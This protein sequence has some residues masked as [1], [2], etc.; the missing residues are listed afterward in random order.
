MTAK[1]DVRTDHIV[2]E[3]DPKIFGHFTEHAFRN[4]YGGIYDPESPFCLKLPLG[5][6]RR[7]EGEPEAGL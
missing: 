6:R 2:G 3:V 1:I 7:T 4:I 5:G